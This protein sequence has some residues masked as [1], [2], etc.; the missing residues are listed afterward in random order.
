M[1]Y[2]RVSE[3]TQ[4]SAWHAASGGAITDEL[5]DWP[6]DLVGLANL[7]LARSGAFPR[8]APTDPG[9][10]SR[11]LSDCGLMVEEAGLR[12]GGTRAA[13]GQG[14]A[15]WRRDCMTPES[16]LL[17]SQSGESPRSR[18]VHRVA[19]RRSND[20][21]PDMRGRLAIPARPASPTADA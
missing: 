15:R 18:L 9:V 12:W 21:K 5:L 3:P 14:V 10:A 7:I 16:L 17:R 8:C 1:R 6:P 19:D 2:D 4:A 13:P 11:G 20:A